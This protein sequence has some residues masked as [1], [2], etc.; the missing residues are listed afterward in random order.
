L[1]PSNTETG[2]VA[3]AARMPAAS[4]AA[5]TDVLTIDWT[6]EEL[7]LADEIDTIDRRPRRLTAALTAARTRAARLI[8]GAAGTLRRNPRKPILITAAL[9]VA[10]VAAVAGTMTAM[11]KTV[12]ITVDGVSRTVTTLSG[13]VEGALETAGITVGAHDSLAPAARSDIADGSQI[14]V[15]RG[16][17]FTATVDGT[18][19]TVWTT[20]TTVSA[21]LSD[22]G[23]Q[24]SEFELSVPASAAVPLSGLSVTAATLHTVSLAVQPAVATP[25]AA[26][27][28]VPSATAAAKS[29]ARTFAATDAAPTDAAPDDAAPAE[30]PPVDY[31]TAARTV[32]DFLK[33]QGLTLAANQEV[34]PAVDTALTDGTAI[35]VVTLP[36]VTLTV[37]TGDVATVYTDASTVGDLLTDKGVKLGSRD[38]VAPDVESPIA[39]G[40]A[41]AVTK[42]SVK[43][44]TR[45]ETVAQPADKLVADASLAA[46]SKKTVTK[47]H[48]GEVTV[49]YHTKVTNGVVGKPYEVSRKTVTPAVASVVHFGTKSSAS[50]SASN[51][52]ASIGAN[53]VDWDAVAQCESGQRWNIN[54][55]NGYYGGL[56]FDIRTWLGNG[57]GKYAPRADLATKA[58]QIDIANYVYAHR[59]LQPWGCGWAG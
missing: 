41:I 26:V 48:P 42:V 43:L 9:V 5:G 55:G 21:A 8:R 13:T 7:E 39:D 19:R 12:T 20:A 10:L 23:E 46:G 34:T 45:S 37:G 30:A 38:Q 31:T 47:G 27:R 28:S 15:G 1:S 4:P 22:M 32:G 59:G 57:G 18:N 16:R 2:R 3:D 53:G 51:A 14:A 54:T 44:T 36:T 11:A 24:A 56:Q 35:S 40:M 29:S 33:E 25:Q 49:Y 6:P 17:T 58:Q 52:P 50:S